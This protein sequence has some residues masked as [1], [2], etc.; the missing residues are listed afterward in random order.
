MSAYNGTL[1]A[2]LGGCT[3]TPL[4]QQVAKLEQENRRLSEERD[5]LR[6]SANSLHADYK[7]MVESNQRINRQLT[8][9]Q[10][11]SSNQVEEI[12][13]LNQCVSAAQNRNEAQSKEI[14]D[15]K[16][17]IMTL[18]FIKGT[19][20]YG[21][22]TVHGLTVDQIGELSNKVANL[23]AD[24]EQSRIYAKAGWDRAYVVS[25]AVDKADGEIKN[26]NTEIDKLKDS[27]TAKINAIQENFNAAIGQWMKLETVKNVEIAALKKEV[28][29]LQS[30][31]HIAL[32]YLASVPSYLSGPHKVRR[33]LEG[34]ARIGDLKYGDNAQG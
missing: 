19:G 2:P 32:G 29:I 7:V 20:P 9:V 17:K 26:L 31:V 12:R 1:G 5:Y 34:N 23:K 6:S 22:V 16:S 14:Q 15:L 25:N 24:L 13:Y 4:S 21:A 27:E 30:K 11:L 33:I 28:S 8:E 10:Q 18:G 3:S